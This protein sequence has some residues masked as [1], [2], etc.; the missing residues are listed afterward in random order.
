MLDGL[1]HA[2]GYGLCHQLPERSFFG[3]GVQVP[4]CARDTGIYVGFVVSLVVLSALSRGRRPRGFPPPRAWAILGLLV[5]TM[6]VDGVSSYAGWRS[7]TN[8]I[9][10][11]TGLAAGFA[12]AAIVLP[13]LNDTLW[14][15]PGQ[16]RR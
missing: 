5:L 8:D 9:R 2:F 10:L 4:V 16:G 15:S 1:L 12:C 6:A 13:M 3:A 11:W 7:T 14:R